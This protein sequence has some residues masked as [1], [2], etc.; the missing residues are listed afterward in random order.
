MWH[1][2]VRSMS[3]KGIKKK[4]SS[5]Q[6]KE[7]MSD[8][9][10]TSQKESVNET[11]KLGSVLKRIVDQ[12][13]DAERSN[14]ETLQE[15]QERL[16]ALAKQT[17]HVKLSYT[18]DDD[19]EI[20][21]IESKIE[22]LSDRI[23]IIS[24]GRTLNADD[25]EERIEALANKVSEKEELEASEDAQKELEE[26]EKTTEASEIKQEEDEVADEEEEVSE[27]E[28]CDDSDIDDADI[29]FEVTDDLDIESV[30]ETQSLGPEDEASNADQDESVKDTSDEGGLSSEERVA[31]AKQL[32]HKIVIDDVDPITKTVE[33]ELSHIVQHLSGQHSSEKDDV[34]TESVA[35]TEVTAEA[36]VSEVLTKSSKPENEK[37]N[38]KLE[39]RF[40]K[41]AEKLEETFKLR[42]QDLQERV[43]ISSKFDELASK[44][45]TWLKS[46]D[47]KPSLDVIE[48]RI[49]NLADYVRKVE[50]QASRI[51]VL[52]N[53]LVKLIELVE[54][55][56]SGGGSQRNLD[57][58]FEE[59][60][61]RILEEKSLKIAD[62]VVSKVGETVG[63]SGYERLEAIQQSIT[64]L[65]SGIS[66][67]DESAH[68]SF[69]EF[70]DTLE[71]M[72]GRLDHLAENMNMHHTNQVNVP[73][74]SENSIQPGSSLSS[75][76]SSHEE[77]QITDEGPYS[78]SP[79]FDSSD[80]KTAADLFAASESREENQNRN[81]L[82]TPHTQDDYI[83]AARNAANVAHEK[84]CKENE[85][86]KQNKLENKVFRV[87]SKYKGRFFKSNKG[88]EEGEKKLTK[89][90]IAVIALL[91]LSFGVL[92]KVLTGSK[93]FNAQ[94]EV[95]YNKPY[96]LNLPR[97]DDDQKSK[98]VHE[99]SKSR[100][101]S[102]G[103]NLETG[104][105]SSSDRFQQTSKPVKVDAQKQVVA[106]PVPEGTG[107]IKESTMNAREGRDILTRDKKPSKAHLSA[108]HKV[109]AKSFS[110]EKA[111][112]GVSVKQ[113]NTENSDDK[114]SG[115]RLLNDLPQG[116]FSQF[117]SFAHLGQQDLSR[118]PKSKTI[119]DYRVG[120]AQKLQL[121]P[122]S[123]G[124]LPLRMAAAKG[125]Y[126]AQFAVAMRYIEGEKVK[127][128]YTSAVRWLRK[129]ATKGFAPAQYHLAAFHEQGYGVKK[130]LL[131]ARTW[132]ERA[133]KKGNV[134]AMHNLAVL[135]L[136]T[137]G[138]KPDHEQAAKWF[139]QAG[140]RGLTDSQY[141][142]GILYKNGLGVTK[143]I[144][145]AFKWFALADKGGDK[146]AARQLNILKQNLDVRDLFLGKAAFDKWRQ[147]PI[148]RNANLSDQIKS[149]FVG[150][151]GSQRDEL[152]VQTQILLNKLGYNIGVVDGYLGPKTRDAI[153]AF[154]TRK[155]L[156]AT[157]KVSKELLDKLNGH[158]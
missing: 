145:E 62:I 4:K 83:N 71:T 121:P 50:S 41:I 146:Q 38:G 118:T 107:H 137:P 3:T 132:Y 19:Q 51:D 69:A 124:S 103:E 61:S 37:K 35:A 77:S 122:E 66:R 119:D 52:E 125:N 58:S 136:Q 139:L 126:K 133:A 84:R 114:G 72:S 80:T 128:N 7:E 153:K 29:T 138:K 117:S 12:I 111:S 31:L 157:G 33:R 75:I 154:Q 57:N 11:H 70:N 9:S 67:Q 134:K 158:V 53:Q 151:L 23:E 82:E 113:D 42:E 106:K 36:D 25:L 24:Q 120:P 104:S 98:T 49:D 109:R 63:N 141:N 140:N 89:T 17:S 105:V 28:A 91:I 85:E 87:F 152:T 156:E 108:I 16:S 90:L 79:A 26:D 112:F 127:R 100:L 30:E 22:G 40:A 76:T 20:Q 68:N 150:S 155:G 135:H 8:V 34:K 55:N 129:A 147:L 149:V 92:L 81:R 74:L 78:F 10:V 131:K 88:S 45:E 27:E 60:A 39:Q 48:K 73:S 32:D 148:V 93:E 110:N 115:N 64:D 44:F 43:D 86:K 65:N 97:Q 14:S 95:K 47:K 142:L 18:D 21:H 102:D 96:Q 130:D 54:N 99:K 46:N 94:K 116:S 101:S 143:N 6:R 59:I 144:H 1:S 5:S 2:G 15:M 13:D 123:I 56:N